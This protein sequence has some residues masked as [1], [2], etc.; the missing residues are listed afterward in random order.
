MFPKNVDPLAVQRNLELLGT[1]RDNAVH[2]Y[3]AKGFGALLYALAQTCIK[4]F[5]DFMDGTFQHRL[6][7][8]ITWHLLPLG[9][10]PLLMSYPTFL[11]RI[12]KN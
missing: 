9:I 7:D 3:N 5:R 2:F 11:A 4:N 8:E 1:Y 10:Q 12:H 6:E